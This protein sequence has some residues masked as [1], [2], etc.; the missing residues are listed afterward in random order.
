MT[1]PT[2]ARV[3]L[4][5]PGDL[6]AALPGMLGFLPVDSVVLV[7]FTGTDRLTVEAVL[8]TDLPEPDHVL[9]LVDQLR[10]V[11]RNHRPSVVALVVLGAAGTEQPGVLPH[12]PL[13]ELLAATFDSEGIALAHA[14]WAPRIERDVTW[15]CYRDI[16]CCGVVRDPATSPVTTAMAVAGAVTFASREDMA[17]LLA[18]DPADDLARRSDLIDELSR[19]HGGPAGQ[20]RAR[21]DLEL[22]ERTI[23]RLASAG[24]PGAGGCSAFEPDDEMIARLARAV[25]DPDVR[26]ACLAYALTERARPAEALWTL[27]TRATPG[28][29]RAEAASLLAVSAYLRGEGALAGMA[30]DVAIEANPEHGLASTMHDVIAFGVPPGQFRSMLAESFARVMT[31]NA[32]E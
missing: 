4:D 25:S 18:A 19:D 31:R 29:A 2:R 17:A 24:T 6:I 11:V 26:E 5:H 30:A 10:I 20:H 21:Q 16:E 3:L 28:R 7:T 9:D 12:R 22:V 32:R 13:V 1:T 14:V 8:R 27:L 15:R 23:D